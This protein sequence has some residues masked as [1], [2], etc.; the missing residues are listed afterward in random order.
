MKAPQIKR[1]DNETVKKRWKYVIAHAAI[2]ICVGYF[3]RVLHENYTDFIELIK[4]PTWLIAAAGF[5]TAIN[6]LFFHKG[7]TKDK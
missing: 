7:S 1:V 5:I 6:Q 3:L 2:Y 4:N